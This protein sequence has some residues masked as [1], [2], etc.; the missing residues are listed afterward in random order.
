MFKFL[1]RYNKWI[2]AVGGTL[3]LITFLVPQ[4][5]TGLSQASATGGSTWAKLNSNG[6]RVTARQLLDLQKELR[7]LQGTIGPQNPLRLLGA[8]SNPGHWYLLTREADAAGLIGGPAEGLRSLEAVMT[9]EQI[10]QEQALALM[11]ASTG[12]S[13]DM[14]LNTMAKAN[15]VVRLLNLIEASARFSDQRLRQSAAKLLLGVSGDVVI[16]DA[17]NP[18]TGVD[19]P[20]P[21]AEQLQEQLDK[22]ADQL[23]DAQ[24]QFGYRLPDRL[25]LE[26]LI[27]PSDLIRESVSSSSDMNNIE[28]RKYFQRNIDQF[29]GDPLATTAPDFNTFKEAVRIQMLEQLVDKKTRQIEKYASD[30]LQLGRRGLQKTS[31]YY[32]FDQQWLD[33]R[34]TF[35]QLGQKISSEF[36]LPP[37]TV[38]STEE[39]IQPGDIN[40]LEIVGEATTDR[41]GST[42]T[43][44]S[45]LTPMAKEFSQDATIPIQQNIAG[46]ATRTSGNDI[47]LFRITETDPSREPTDLE[48]VREQV[49]QDTIALERFDKLKNMSDSIRQ[50]AIDKGLQSVASSFDSKLTFVSQLREADM[51]F[52]RS[53]LIFPGQIPGLGRSENVVSEIVDQASTL[54]MDTNISELPVSERLMVIPDEQTLSLV[55]FKISDLYPMTQED[56]DTLATGPG[57]ARAIR[58]S[59][60]RVDVFDVFSFDSLQD[61][62]GFEYTRST[63]DEE[64]DTENEQAVATDDAGDDQDNG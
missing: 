58:Q 2:L 8:D 15:G 17:S 46:P 54:P 48:E 35:E 5:I 25:K 11:S 4:A 43:R 24:N 12:Q 19:V 45:Q 37:L 27:I 57:L 22:H 47:V 31:G 20:T 26:W 23:A 64:I 56:F 55:I 1:R 42:P 59:E 40:Q 62:W 9:N 53:G 18:D 16:I 21:T 28:M 14:V 36:K 41:F 60:P 44:I 10:T 63:I 32:V 61:R 51:Q 30:Q 7:V 6:E 34:E 52:L 29:S 39:W 33:Q 3:L 38:G 49:E 13:Q 50:Q